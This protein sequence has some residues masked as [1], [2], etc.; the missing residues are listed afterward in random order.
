MKTP[1]HIISTAITLSEKFTPPSVSAGWLLGDASGQ[2]AVQFLANYSSHFSISATAGDLLTHLKVY[3]MNELSIANEVLQC[4]TLQSCQIRALH[5]LM[6]A[7]SCPMPC[8]EQLILSSSSHFPAIAGNRVF[9]ANVCQLQGDHLN[10]F[11]AIMKVIEILPDPFWDEAL[12]NSNLSSHLIKAAENSTYALFLYLALRASGNWHPILLDLLGQISTIP[13]RLIPHN[14]LFGE[15]R[16]LLAIFDGGSIYLSSMIGMMIRNEIIVDMHVVDN[17][18]AS[19]FVRGILLTWIIDAFLKT[20]GLHVSGTLLKSV[21]GFV[22][23]DCFDF[24]S[25]CVLIENRYRQKYMEF[26]EKRNVV[27]KALD[28]LLSDRQDMIAWME[29]YQRDQIAQVEAIAAISPSPGHLGVEM[30]SIDDLMRN[31]H[32]NIDNRPSRK[33]S[34]YQLIKR[35]KPIHWADDFKK[36][37]EAI[38]WKRCELEK[39]DRVL[40]DRRMAKY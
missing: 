16:Q 22:P 14:A 11:R 13:D 9:A 19:G 5:R 37:E 12:K 1:E 17:L 34:M 27:L 2:R 30:E 40:M 3:Y 10:D 33:Q 25:C 4:T 32:L 38:F 39:Y 35:S 15:Q 29:K 23:L 31:L 20:R 28:K 18:I 6:E 21:Q 8:K 7:T 36:I 24:L 26:E